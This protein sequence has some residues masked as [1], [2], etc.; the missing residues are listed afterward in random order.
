MKRFLSI[1]CSFV[2]ALGLLSAHIAH[3]EEAAAQSMNTQDLASA[4]GGS[5]ADIDQEVYNNTIGSI[6]YTGNISGVYVENNAG[7]TNVIQNTGNQVSLA[8][9]TVVNITY[10]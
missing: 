3:A 8:T 1:T 9:A 4:S 7:V 10:H 5:E 2:L 6:G